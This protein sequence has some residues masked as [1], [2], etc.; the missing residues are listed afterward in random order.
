M[1]LVPKTTRVRHV[2]E[3]FKGRLSG[4][5]QFRGLGRRHG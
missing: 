5:L 1:R 4:M 2:P 3:S